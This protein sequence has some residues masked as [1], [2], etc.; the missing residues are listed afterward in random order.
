MVLVQ[1]KAGPAVAVEAA[2]VVATNVLASRAAFGALVDI[3]NKQAKKYLPCPDESTKNPSPPPARVRHAH[4]KSNFRLDAHC[5]RAR[6]YFDRN[7][8]DFIE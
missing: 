2:D 3:C 4:Q 7:N 1:L 5:P 8:F 6:E